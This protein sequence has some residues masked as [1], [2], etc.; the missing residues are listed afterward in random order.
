MIGLDTNILLRIIVED[1]PEQTARVRRLTDEAI[2]T[3]ELL[4]ITDV[5]LSETVWTLRT[6][7]RRNRREI[8]TTLKSIEQTINFK[9]ESPATIRKAIA[10]FEH[11]RGDFPDYLIKERCNSAGCRTVAT[12]DKV[13]LSE[14]G[15]IEP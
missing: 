12:F 1:D 5:V 9:F 14:P 7:Y 15:F 4:F 13:L 8:L 3:G 10:D 2:E 11:N 6:G